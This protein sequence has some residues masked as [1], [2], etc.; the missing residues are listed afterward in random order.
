MKDI[1]RGK[2]TDDERAEIERL[3]ESMKRLSA[4]AIARRLNRHP[5]TV[6]W[7][8]LRKG[9]LERKIQ[10]RVDRVY[11]RGGT[12]VVRY[13]REEESVLVDMRSQGE[14][15]QRIAEALTTQFGER[16]TAHSVQVRDVFLSAAADMEAA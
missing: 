3:A 13:S 12:R 14:T 11:Y 2:L 9:Y 10:Y 4:N 6:T 15:Y 5:A 7:Y 1:R 8:L 16:R